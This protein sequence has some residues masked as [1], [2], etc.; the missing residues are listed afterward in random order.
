MTTLPLQC[1]HHIWTLPSAAANEKVVNT[2]LNGNYSATILHS[3]A[4]L[5]IFATDIMDLTN[6]YDFTFDDNYL[7][8][9][10]YVCFLQ[11]DEVR[12]GIHAGNATFHKGGNSIAKIF[13]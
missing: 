12:R 6:I 10:E 2:S 3:Q 7:T 9:H 8:N 11:Q 5:H 4:S 1:G 13:P